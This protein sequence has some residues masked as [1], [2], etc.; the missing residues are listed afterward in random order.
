M[1]VTHF[2]PRNADDGS[3]Q[4]NPR[5]L[6]G[7]F[8]PNRVSQDS[9]PYSQAVPKPGCVT[10]SEKTTTL[11]LQHHFLPLGAKPVGFESHLLFSG[12]P[13]S[14]R[15]TKFSGFAQTL[16]TYAQLTLSV[17]F[18]QSGHTSQAVLAVIKKNIAAARNA[19]KPSNS[20]A[21]N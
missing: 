4:P 2:G 20:F 3:S 8:T 11:L 21:M 19:I 18:A 9:S 1:N 12:S 15:L 7:T 5:H 6:L 13:P 16:S 17:L 10:T 14:Y